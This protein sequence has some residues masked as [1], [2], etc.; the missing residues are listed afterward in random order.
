[1]RLTTVLSSYESLM[2]KLEVD[3]SMIEKEK[4]KIVEI[5]EDYVREVHAN[6]GKIDRNSTIT[7]RDR[8]IKMLKIQIPGWEENENLY[9]VRLMDFMDEI[10]AR[11]RASSGEPER[12]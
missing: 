12:L 7:V 1:M 2:E 3:I 6:L 10:T 8:Q 4:D 9:H 5:L 11:D